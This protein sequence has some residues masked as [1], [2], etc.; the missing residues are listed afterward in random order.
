[1][2]KALTTM[3]G[4]DSVS[5]GARHATQGE[6]GPGRAGADAL[7]HE[8]PRRLD[9]IEVVRVR[10]Q[11]A[12]G[13]PALFDEEAH[14]QRLMRGEIVEQ[15]HVTTPQARREPA[16][17]PFD[18]AFFG[19]RAPFRTQRHPATS[20][21]RADQRQVVSPVHRP[22]LHVFFAALDPGVGAAH[23]DVGAG[24]IEEDQPVGVD[25]THPLQERRALL[26]DIRPVNFTRA[27]PFFLST[28]PARRNAR[29]KLDRVVRRLLGTRRLY[30]Q[31][32]SVTVASG[33]SRTTARSTVVSMGHDQPPPLGCGARDSV[34]RH[35]ATQRSS[36]RWS[37]SK[38]AAR[39]AYDPSPR[40][41]AVTARSRSARSYGFGMAPLKYSSPGNSSGIRE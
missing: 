36:V 26:G 9:R 8:R 6:R 38:S 37:T 21:H 24:F 10:R 15:D 32:N 11:V 29:W 22:G 27:R 35:R 1:M 20:A 25:A 34:S 5:G 7:L 28:K 17:N 30:S 33:P 18:E 40:S 39:S 12:H 41:Y 19:H 4:R 14:L 31:H 2:G 3:T 16:P 23:R 13:G